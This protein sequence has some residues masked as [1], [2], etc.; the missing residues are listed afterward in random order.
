MSGIDSIEEL[1]NQ[2]ERLLAE[3][4]MLIEKGIKSTNPDEF[5][6]AQKYASQIEERSEY[7]GKAY[8]IDPNDLNR[9]FGYKNKFTNTSFELLRAA[10]K[11]PLIFSIIST[12]I[13]RIAEFCVPQPNKYAPGFV[14]KQ[15]KTSF[16]NDVP[17]EPTQQIKNLIDEATNFMLNC[18]LGS[19]VFQGDTFETFVRKISKDSLELDQM[20]FEV[21]RNKKKEIDHFVAVDAGTIR[22]ADSFS[23]ADYEKYISSSTKKEENGYYP[24]YVQVK[25]SVPVAEFYPWELC[26]GVR[27]QTTDIH[28]NGYGLSEI[29]VLMRVI[30]EMLDAEAYNGNNFKNGSFPKG[31]WKLPS[32]TS[33]TKLNEF[34]NQWSA[35]V[36]GVARAHSTLSIEGK[37]IEWIDMQK[38]NSDMEY[39]S[40]IQFLIKVACAVFKTTPEDIGFSSQGSETS[41][42]EGNNQTKLEHSVN[43]GLKPYLRFLQNQLNKFIVWQRYPELEFE[44]V[45]LDADDEKAEVDMDIRKASS[46]MTLKEIRRKYNLPEDIDENDILLNPI[47]MQSKQMQMQNNPN[48][49]DMQ[50]TDSVEKGFDAIQDNF[51]KFYNSIVK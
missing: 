48:D 31:V 41:L 2:R 45:G 18:G 49:S 11:I 14:I 9:S 36:Q 37:D 1:R 50:E 22:I 20:T 5:I 42:F 25:D 44:F 21:I 17:K 26:F 19:N 47:Y 43:K 28:S 38:N 35:M 30:T 33:P 51:D 6:K 39:N 34:R 7:N 27:N 24:S 13:D 29:E 16:S 23:D 15:R 32:G 8:L 4:M 46:F 3:E 12:K 10:A 40:W